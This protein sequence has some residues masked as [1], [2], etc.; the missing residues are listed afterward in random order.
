MKIQYISD[1]HLE[2][3]EEFPKIKVLAEHICLCGDIGYPW[4]Q[5]YKDFIRYCSENYTNVFVIFGNHEYYSKRKITMVE[6]QNHILSFP[7][8][9]YYLNNTCLYL[10]KIKGTVCKQPKN[11]SH[12]IKIIGSTLWSNI[13]GNAAYRVNDYYQIKI[14]PTRDL[15]RRDTLEMF[16]VSKR[17]ILQEIES[18]PN[19][20]CILMTHHGTHEL[21]NGKYEMNSFSTAFVTHI[22]EIFDNAN[23]IAAIN[24]H[25][26][27]SINCT[28]GTSNIKLLA[29]CYGY[30]HETPRE[31][32]P[33]AI[34]EI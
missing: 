29:N 33:D 14:S 5:I 9:V 12:Y 20:P 2:L 27:S 34:L 31:Y 15:E 18:E 25:T 24:G 1:I 26:H 28:V 32:N 8:N 17:Y 13:D 10:H 6:I 4:T 21:C 3:L 30:K 16:H 22:P 19:V 7:E 11:K 23:L